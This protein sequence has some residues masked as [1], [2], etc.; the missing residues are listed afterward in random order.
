[1]MN[2]IKWVNIAGVEC[3]ATI[4]PKRLLL[5]SSL[6]GQ[7]YR[8]VVLYFQGREDYITLGFVSKEIAEELM[9]KLA[10]LIVDED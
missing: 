6:D 9:H 10:L 1:M 4:S 5:A 2:E 3:H 7:T 8:E